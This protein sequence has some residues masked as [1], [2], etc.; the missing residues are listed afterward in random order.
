MENSEL[1]AL[2]IQDNEEF[3]R[4]ISTPVDL[5][6]DKDLIR[7][8]EKLEE[9]CKQNEVLAMAA[10]Q[11][12][13]PKRLVYLKNTSLEQTRKIQMGSLTEEDLSY[14]EAKII[15]NPVIINQEGLTEYWEACA[16]CL[17]YCGRVLRP[18]SIEL[19]YYDINKEKHQEKFEGFAATV[20]S[21]EIDHLDG[22][23][24]LDIAEEVLI[25]SVEERKQWRK[26]H[27]YKIYSR[28]G[29]YDA[30]KQQEKNNNF[31]VKR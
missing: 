3:L 13:I 5:K 12:G 24:H 17:D 20:L 7:E 27:D 28:K 11:V 16:S 30:L 6:S 23:L 22:I 29:D 26:T 4:Q 8:V 9:Y 31:N 1:Q 15:I 19:E 14:N 10:V 2:T 25:M 21:H 18:Y